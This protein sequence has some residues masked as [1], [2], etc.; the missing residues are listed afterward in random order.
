MCRQPGGWARPGGR[1]EPPLTPFPWPWP[2][3]P[4][5][6]HSLALTAG[7]RVPL[8]GWGERPPPWSAAAWLPLAGHPG[9]PG[10]TP[11]WPQ[12]RA[13]LQPPL[14]GVVMETFG[15]GNGP[16]K[17]DLLR[18]LRAAAARGLLI[19][20]CTHCLQGTVTSDYAA[21]MVG[22]AQR[23]VEGMA[24]RAWWAGLGLERVGEGTTAPPARTPTPLTPPPPAP[25][26]RLWWA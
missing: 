14:K 26:C 19:L 10:L 21:G 24:Q 8:G 1:W 9:R 5:T 11:A 6:S 20:N 22:R 16:T 3:H 15:S 13:F 12:V 7:A 2:W 23:G 18:E 4:H 25:L 17:P